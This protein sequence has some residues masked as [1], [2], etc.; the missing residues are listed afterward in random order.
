MRLT[1]LGLLVGCVLIQFVLASVAGAT[2]PWSF[3]VI[4]DAMNNDVALND[5]DWYGDGL[6]GTFDDGTHA[7][8]PF[9][10]NAMAAESPDFVLVPGDLVQGRWS[11]DAFSD[12]QIQDKINSDPANFGHLAGKSGVEARKDH[13]RYMADR[14][15]PDWNQMWADHGIS[16]V[17]SIPGDHEFG[18]NNWGMSYD[19][20]VVPVYREKYEEYRGTPAG[21][22]SYADF[23]GRTFSL[24][25]KNLTLVGV[26]VFDDNEGGNV[27]IGVDGAHLAF[28]ENA[29]N[30]STTDHKIAMA[31]TP[32]LPGSPKRSSSGLGLPGGASSGLWQALVGGDADMYL[33]GEVHDIS[34]QE[35][36]NLLQMVAGSQPSNVSEFNYLL[37]TV[38]DDRLELELKLLETTLDGPRDFNNDPYEVDPYLE[39]Q[40]KLT[41]AQRDAGFQSVGTMTIDKSTGER[42]FISKT[43]YFDSSR[44][45]VLDPAPQTGDVIQQMT[46]TGSN[47]EY[48]IDTSGFGVGAK[49]YT[50]REY[51]WAN[52]PSEGDLPSYLIGAEYVATAND[53]K[54][55][56]SLQIDLSFDGPS[57]VYVFFDDRAAAT[58]WLTDQFTDTGD[59]MKYLI[60][61]DTYSDGTWSVWKL[62]LTEAGTVTL[63]PRGGTGNGMYMIAAIPEPASLALLGLGGL[64]TLIARR[65][66][67]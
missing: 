3:V 16:N 48:A 10:L 54:D 6:D 37:V 2:P 4:P 67:R 43:G 24:S 64:G 60:D 65:R 8:W 31:H 36:G 38:Y 53:D 11:L 18:D 7:A 29:L 9:T 51:T 59:D 46:V 35:Q 22:T 39:R 14:F 12:S 1:S 55:N 50:D 27:A 42:Q 21:A 15:Y 34:M 44:Y 33:A 40:V 19:P 25:H 23:D 63:G 30:N 45:S 41:Q 61:E 47:R 32:I 17:Y 26:D 57:D 66:R 56:G 5:P 20:D 52:S 13:V 62:S 58:S 28:V 49:V